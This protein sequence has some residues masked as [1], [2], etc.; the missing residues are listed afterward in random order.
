MN[1]YLNYVHENEIPYA[2]SLH[3]CFL[4]NKLP[5]IC[6]LY[7]RYQRII[8]ESKIHV[9][10]MS[11]SYMLQNNVNAYKLLYVSLFHDIS[12]RQLS[13]KINYLWSP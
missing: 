4:E 13:M 11:V 9:P 5:C 1:E 7:D 10:C 6:S 3:D 12:L 8:G 2:S